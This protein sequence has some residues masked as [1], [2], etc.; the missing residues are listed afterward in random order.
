MEVDF[1]NENADENIHSPLTNE[2]TE[3]VKSQNPE[4]SGQDHGVERDKGFQFENNDQNE[5]LIENKEI[6]EL[7]PSIEGN[8]IVPS[9]DAVVMEKARGLWKEID[10]VDP[11]DPVSNIEQCNQ[12]NIFTNTKIIAASRRGRSHAHEGKYREDSFCVEHSGAWTFIAVADGT[13]SK[14]LARIGSRLA[15]HAAV[16]YLQQQLKNLSIEESEQFEVNLR[17]ALAGAMV[18][19]LTCLT[20]EA[21]RRKCEINDLSTTLLIVA[22]IPIHES[23]EIIGVAQVGDGGI[24]VR[25]SDEH[26]FTL[27]AADHG[28]YGGESLFLTSQET[29]LSWT[30]RVFLYQVRKPFRL[31][32]VATDGVFDDFSKP[33]GELTKLFK[34][35]ENI[36][37]QTHPEEWLTSWLSYE[38]R[39]SFDDRTIA[40]L[41]PS[42]MEFEA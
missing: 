11:T 12:I 27:G 14:P 38:R 31:L 10:P 22:Y 37:I 6:E 21:V 5:N 32:L 33:Y 29:Q 28:I 7:L 16:D 23:L 1:M 40:L 2:T 4:E 41:I 30:K 19:A 34:E 3:S 9:P 26:V 8:H 24:A 25:D 35:L 13:G 39:G 36:R 18:N 15:A 42:G 17:C 20:S